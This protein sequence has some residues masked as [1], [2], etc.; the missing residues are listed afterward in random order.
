MADEASS[1]RKV[2]LA[3]VSSM[4]HGVLFGFEK[5]L[6]TRYNADSKV[7]IPYIMDELDDLFKNLHI[8][9]PELTVDENLERIKDFFSNEEVM[10]GISFDK[11]SDGKYNFVVK[12]CKFATSGVHDLLEMEK[13]TC[14]WALIIGAVI[15][16]SLDNDKYV[17]VCESEYTD[18]GSSTVLEI[19]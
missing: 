7:F 11:M 13:G 3:E 6:L 1:D 16:G 19:K 4:L 17:D 2:S 5:V 18:E 8:V 12:E 10:D 9:D 14:P 15:T